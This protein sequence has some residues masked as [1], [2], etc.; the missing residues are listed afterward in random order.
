MVEAI[1]VDEF[2]PF[3]E[4]LEI[5]DRPEMLGGPATEPGWYLH[6]ECMMGCCESAG[7]F[8]TLAA[9]VEADRV[10][11]E[12][13]REGMKNRDRSAPSSEYDDLF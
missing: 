8:R 12:Q 11:R 2:P 1:F 3:I 4:F 9:A 5:G 6:P 10:L 7:P 13:F